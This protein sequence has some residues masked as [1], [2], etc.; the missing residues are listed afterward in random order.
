MNLT[1]LVVAGMMALVSSAPQPGVVGLGSETVRLMPDTMTVRVNLTATDAQFDKALASIQKQTDDVQKALQGLKMPP[2]EVNTEGPT[3]GP[4]A[5]GGREDIL[6]MQMMRAMGRD[7]TAPKEE[8]KVTLS[9]TVSADWKLAAQDAVAL[10]KETE[11]IEEAVRAALPKPAEQPADLTEAQQE[12]MLSQMGNM[13][14][15]GP[16]PGTPTFTFSAT[17]PADK[18][19]AARKTA[20]QRAVADAKSLAEAGGF[21]T[22][23][24]VSM[25]GSVSPENAEESY[26]I[27]SVPWFTRTAETVATSPGP[28]ELSFN[29]RM[30]VTFGLTAP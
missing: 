21:T 14:Q 18:L 9:T 3:L 10:L 12:E 20:F 8:G 19:L 6:R 15:N 7:T 23:G 5:G 16:P 17:L 1:A 24:L 26:Y 2:A 28:I 29:V 30:E 11:A 22:G 4:M 25:S 13:D 27:Q